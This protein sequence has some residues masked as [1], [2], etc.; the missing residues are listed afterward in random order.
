MGFLADTKL[1]AERD[2]VSLLV[3]TE[4]LGTGMPAELV[5][6]SAPGLWCEVSCCMVTDDQDRKGLC[7]VAVVFVPRA[8]VGYSQIISE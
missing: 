6:G 4:C 3:R 5:T 2:L 1:E 7:S 8:A